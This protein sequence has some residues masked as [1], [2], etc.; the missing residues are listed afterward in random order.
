MSKCWKC[1]A[2]LMCEEE[3]CNCKKLS[4]DKDDC[5]I[6]F[7]KHKGMSFKD[8]KE[9]YP[10]YLEWAMSNIPKRKLD[11]DLYDYIYVN[12]DEIMANSKKKRRQ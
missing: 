3:P 6:K 1:K 10:D 4:I 9:L 8:I 12:R 11:N 7:G 5:T 2:C